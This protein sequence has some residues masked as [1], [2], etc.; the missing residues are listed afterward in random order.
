V[1]RQGKKGYVDLYLR[2]PVCRRPAAASA[3]SVASVARA[4][5]KKKRRLWG[6]DHGGRFR[7][8]GKNSHATVRGTRWVVEDSCKGTLT[9]VTSGFV[10]V[11]DTVRGKRVRVDAG[12][13]YLAR[14][15]R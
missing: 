5:K 6:K 1:I 9:R 2:G 3:A 14:P 13:R 12:E 15:R 7:T 11:T 4:S 10:I 8:H